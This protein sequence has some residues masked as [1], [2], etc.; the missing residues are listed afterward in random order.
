MYK[1]IKIVDI[2]LS[3]P[4]ADIEG[5]DGY[6]SLQALVRLHGTPIG[7]IKIP[8]TDGI[9]TAA[10]ISRSVQKGHG[11]AI[12][13]HLLCDGLLTLPSPGRLRIGDLL[14]ISHPV[15]N[16]P[17]P[18][19]TVVVCTR[20]RVADLARCLDSLCRLDYPKLDI[21][22]VDNAPNSTAT[23]QLVR[24]TYPNVRYVCEPRPGL[25]WARNRGV[26][27]SPAAR[28]SLTPMTTW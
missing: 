26:I 8:I 12:I 10:A 3:R 1:P 22:V 13:R 9:C 21:L 28:L 24:A 20:D 15:Y 14:D 19:V 23:E 2:E 4:L 6:G 25:D 11:H 18:L 27:L 16:G 5:V 7:Y 17:L